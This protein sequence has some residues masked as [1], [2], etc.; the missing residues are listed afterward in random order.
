[1][2]IWAIGD[3]HASRVDPTTG[4]PEKPMDVFGPKWSNHVKRIE[5]AWQTSVADGDTVIL[6]GDL[7]WALHLE[8]A[9]PT[10]D[11]IDQWKGHKLLIRGNHDYWWSS[12]ATAKVRCALPRSMRLIHNDAVEVEG[13]NVVGAKGSPVPGGMDWTDVEAKLL[14]RESERLKLSLAQRNPDLPSICALHYPPFYPCSSDTPYTRLMEEAN[15]YLC[16]YGHLHGDAS[17]GGPAGVHEGIRYRLVAA[18]HLDFRPVPVARQG[19]IVE[20]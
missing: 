6:A 1:M 14:N 12:K 11:M 3:I 9:L 2:T 15:V 5:A 13:F 8:D 16:V 17:A 18:D 19:R 20:A 7:D 10:L 4:L